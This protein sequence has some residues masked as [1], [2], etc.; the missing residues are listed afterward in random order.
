MIVLMTHYTRYS[1]ALLALVSMFA[2]SLSVRAEEKKS[3][4]P[5]VAKPETVKREEWGS[6]PQPLPEELLHANLWETA[7]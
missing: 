3:E 1:L 7:L 4:K 6:A 5:K 2:I